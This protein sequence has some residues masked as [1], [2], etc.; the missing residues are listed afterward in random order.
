MMEQIYMSIADNPTAD[1]Y[2]QSA[3]YLQEE[4]K[5]QEKAL[6]WLSKANDLAGDQYYIHRVWSLVLAQMKEYDAAIE[7]AEKSKILASLQGKDE[8]V[9]MNEFSIQE[10]R[11]ASGKP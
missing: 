11:K 7:H 3:R 6:E 5:M 10:W 1:T 8:F 4:N 9:R 2:Y